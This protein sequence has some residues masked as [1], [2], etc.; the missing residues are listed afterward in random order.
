MEMVQTILRKIQIV[1]VLLTH[2]IAR[3]QQALREQQVLPVQPAL[4]EQPELQAQLALPVQQ[5]QTVQPEQLVRKALQGLFKNTMCMVLRAGLP[6]QVQ[7]PLYN[8]D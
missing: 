4:R 5:E 6:L 1:M 3:V 7:E 8:R 2:W